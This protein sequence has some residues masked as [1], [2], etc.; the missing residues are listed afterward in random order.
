MKTWART[1]LKEV[2]SRAFWR[3]ELQLRLLLIFHVGFSINNI[4]SL[5][6][7]DSVQCSCDPDCLPSNPCGRRKA[8]SYNDPA[9]YQTVIH[10]ESST[11]K[12]AQR[13]IAQS[14][15]LT[16]TKYIGDHAWSSFLFSNKQHYI[17][18]GMT[19]QELQNRYVHL[20]WQV[21]WITTYMGT[22]VTRPQIGHCID[23][24]WCWM[25]RES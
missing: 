5:W 15:S 7:R 8:V 13:A 6:E 1:P 19:L 14:D 3:N 23:N 18:M 2:L 16:L 9:T 25:Y 22:D 21:C 20:G 10:C 24:R 4:I 11:M 12:W 17:S